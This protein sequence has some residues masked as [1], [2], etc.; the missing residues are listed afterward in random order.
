MV[1]PSQ[2]GHYGDWQDMYQRNMYQ[3]NNLIDSISQTEIRNIFL[4]YGIRYRQSKVTLGD[5]LDP[6]YHLKKENR[7]FKIQ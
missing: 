4:R 3:R 1:Y 2:H 5:S 6:G 7:R